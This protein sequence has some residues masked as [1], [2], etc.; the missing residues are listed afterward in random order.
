MWLPIT[1]KIQY[2]ILDLDL[3][4]TYLGD[5][6]E[7]FWIVYND[8]TYYV[9]EP[10]VEEDDGWLHAILTTTLYHYGNSQLTNLN[11]INIS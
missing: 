2:T 1:F 8:R 6:V 4:I 5:E 7:Y 9:E 10:E 3:R 11:D